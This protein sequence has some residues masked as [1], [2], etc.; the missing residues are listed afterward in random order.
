MRLV[1]E[2]HF[3]SD[4]NFEVYKFLGG[5]MDQYEYTLVRYDMRGLMVDTVV[6]AGKH[7]IQDLLNDGWRVVMDKPADS[8]SKKLENAA[9]LAAMTG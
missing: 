5:S 7:E 8:N 9:K 3:P 2:F 6:C 1:S 4:G